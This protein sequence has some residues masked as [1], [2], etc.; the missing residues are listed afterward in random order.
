[1]LIFQLVFAVIAVARGC[2]WKLPMLLIIITFLAGYCIGYYDFLHGLKGWSDILLLGCLV[3][4]AFKSYG[5]KG[6]KNEKNI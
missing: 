6:K 3:Y 4:L 2:S 1:M 5:I